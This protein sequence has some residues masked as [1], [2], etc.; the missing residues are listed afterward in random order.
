[1]PVGI[2]ALFIIC[3]TIVLIILIAAKYYNDN[4]KK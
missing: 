2:Q 4:D 1:M 3:M